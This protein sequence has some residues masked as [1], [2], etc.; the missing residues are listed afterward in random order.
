VD[1]KGIVVRQPKNERINVSAL[2]VV[3]PACEK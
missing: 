2:E 1:V 3:S